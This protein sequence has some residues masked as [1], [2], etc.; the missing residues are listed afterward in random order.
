MF[1]RYTRAIAVIIVFVSTAFG[2]IGTREKK[3]L[4]VKDVILFT[5]RFV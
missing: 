4:K 2:Q 5:Y 1:T 3:R